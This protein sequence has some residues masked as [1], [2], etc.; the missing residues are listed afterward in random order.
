MN[1]VKH[2]KSGECTN[3]PDQ[4]EGRERYGQRAGESQWQTSIER[5]SANV[6]KI[7]W[8]RAEAAGRWR[9]CR[10]MAKSKQRWLVYRDS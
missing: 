9:E 5:R 2:G 10:R 3:Q 7:I 1:N 6:Q 4:R 8:C